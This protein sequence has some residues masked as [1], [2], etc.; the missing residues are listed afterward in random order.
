MAKQ[1]H[2]S[3]TASMAE[4]FAALE[5]TALEDHPNPD[6]IDCPSEEILEVFARSPRELPMNHPL[7]GHLQSCS[8]CFRFVRS[9]YRRT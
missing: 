8:P 5:K 6:R 4:V 2:A 3:A 1:D 9:R 7:F